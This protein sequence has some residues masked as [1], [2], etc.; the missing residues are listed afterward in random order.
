[1]DRAMPWVHFVPIS[2]DY[3]DLYDVLTFFRGTPDGKNAHD[4]L[5]E[6]IATAG[7]DWAMNFWRQDVRAIP[8][9]G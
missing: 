9:P 6:K 1:M 4:D 5:A 8:P 2:V 3:G 7:R